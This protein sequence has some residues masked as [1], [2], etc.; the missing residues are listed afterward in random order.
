[1]ARLLGYDVAAV[2]QRMAESAQR[3]RSLVLAP[4]GFGKS[5]LLSVVRC[6][7]EIVRDPDVRFLLASNTQAQAEAFVREVRGHLERNRIF[8]R[9][10]GDQ[11][12]PKWND[13]ELIVRGRKRI[14]KE[15]TIYATGVGGALVSRHFDVVVCD[16]IVDEENSRTDSRRDRYR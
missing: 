12:G 6:V 5:T 13:R 11:V 16:D 9:V 4:R 3:A 15:P 8:R 7:F 10:F 2:H 14:V 1:M